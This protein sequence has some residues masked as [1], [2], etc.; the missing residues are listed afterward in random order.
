MLQLFDLRLDETPSPF[1]LLL[2]VH[3]CARFSRDSLDLVSED[4]PMNQVQG[5]SICI[6]HNPERVGDALITGRHS[7]WV[8]LHFFRLTRIG[9]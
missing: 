5:R 9:P 8:S 3:T 4:C 6:K 7:R 1:V 2:T